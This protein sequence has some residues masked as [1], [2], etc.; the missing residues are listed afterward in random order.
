MT[1]D[2]FPSPYGVRGTILVPHLSGCDYY[3]DGLVLVRQD[4]VVS[5]C[6]PFHESL[7]RDFGSIRT[8]RGVILPPFLDIHTHISQHPI[9]GKFTEGIEQTT[10]EGRLLEGL[11]RNVYPAEALCNDPNRAEKVIRDF[12]ADTLRHGVVGGCAYMTSNVQATRLA[13]TILP[14]TWRVGMVL[15]DRPEVPENLRTDPGS[16]IGH[17]I[18][19]AEVFG[20]RFVVTDRFAPV[21]SKTLRRS[22]AK[23][24]RRFNLFTQTHLNEQPSEKLLVEKVLYPDYPNYTSVYHR[25]GL[26]DSPCIVAHCVYMTTDE[27]DVFARSGAI[28][29]H[30]PTSN[31]LLGSGRMDL[32]EVIRRKIQYALATDVGASPTV[33]MLAEMGRFLQVHAGRSAYATPSEALYRATLA[34]QNILKMN[35]LVGGLTIGQP[36]SFI[37][38]KPFKNLSSD[39]ASGC[40]ASLISDSLDDPALS[41]QQ[42]TLRGR[43]VFSADSTKPR[44]NTACPT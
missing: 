24:A 42:V 32:D 4:G 38:V 43:C 35:A 33:S 20:D 2:V 7:V 41:V 44:E 18:E 15:M 12:L 13:L 11:K 30:C 16:V 37:E 22:A 10:S 39:D 34:P 9:R 6:G 36:A 3:R 26:F 25:D 40:I 23:I 1:D 21:V 19:L 17:M 8:S 27:W 5:Y 28:I 31:L 14:D 29:A